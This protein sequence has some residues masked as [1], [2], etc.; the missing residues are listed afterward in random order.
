MFSWPAKIRHRAAFVLLGG[1]VAGNVLL[2]LPARQAILPTD[3]C[4]YA[5]IG[6]ALLHGERLYT[7]L[8]DNKPPA[9][10]L[11][12]ALAEKIWG[13][14]TPAVVY[15][16]MVFSIISMIMIF[17]IL[18]RSGGKLPAL[19]G[20]FFWMLASG[21]PNLELIIPNTEFYAA[22]F[23]LVAVWAFLEYLHGR[24]GGLA[25]AG[26][27]MALAT[28]YKTNA[29][30]FL[31]AFCLELFLFEN[32]RDGEK[33][34]LWGK[35]G[36]LLLPSILVW[37]VLGSYFGIQNR[38]MDFYDINFLSIRHYV[39]NIW[40]NEWAHL[41][42]GKL[43]F[44]PFL[45]D[46]YVLVAFAWLWLLMSL[47]GIFR[48][49]FA[50]FYLGLLIGGFLMVGS[51][52]GSVPHPNYYQV[53]VPLYCLM[54]AMFCRDVLGFFPARGKAYWAVAG[55]LFFIPA[56][57]LGCSQG[58]GWFSAPGR[59][60][61]KKEAGSDDDRRLGWLLKS[62][63]RPD[64]TLFQWGTAAGIYFYSGRE[65]ASGIVTHHIL[66]FSPLGVREKLYRKLLGDLEKSRPAF[67][68]F[69]AW[70]FR[71][72]QE[73]WMQAIK[74]R[75]R[76]WAL[77]GKYVVF[78][79]KDRVAAP[80]K[81]LLVKMD[82]PKNQEERPW[83]KPTLEFF[84]GW[85]SISLTDPERFRGM[86]VLPVGNG[87]EAFFI[88]EAL[89]LFKQG[90]FIEARDRLALALAL[91]P[92]S[93]CGLAEMGVYNEATGQYFL[94]LENYQAAAKYRLHPLNEYYLETQ[95]LLIQQAAFLAPPGR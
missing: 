82:T 5:Y 83:E 51:I 44:T 73:P 60:S 79:K 43:F 23:L 92:E 20:A 58:A 35:M 59:D 14:G 16:G 89:E 64:E 21:S 9:I 27:A 69:T 68:V 39:G 38:F 41:V 91:N 45:K 25:V 76:F 42:S 62:L 53:M 1:L 61:L 84:P 22:T 80:S 47:L 6:H 11:T 66:F 36:K 8:V 57:S 18:N 48:R 19:L 52:Q 86:P 13:Y 88:R 2:R 26:T 54:S 33:G 7:D 63:T 56:A 46:V 3:N 50:Y 12:Y 70:A 4:I 65:A 74:T 85:R 37:I 95:A 15:L 31:P 71:L 75:Y 93:P 49:K 29:F 30:F 34:R 90:R 67:I 32:E 17:L 72:D 94:A 81:E 78:E 40:L 55:L 28:L 24:R 87:P 77:Y 10:Y